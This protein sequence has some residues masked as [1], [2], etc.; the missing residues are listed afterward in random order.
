MV[1]APSLSFRVV[2]CALAAAIVTA[3][4]SDG[5]EP[6]PPGGGTGDA[7]V[8]TSAPGAWSA[9]ASLP[10]AKQELAVVAIGSKVYVLGGL[11]GAG[12]SLAIVHVYDASSDTW[13]IGPPLP[14]PMH[15]VNAAVADGRIY[16]VGA[17]EGAGF[18]ATGDV[19]MLDPSAGAWTP[20][21]PMPAG[22]ERGAAM[23]A[24][25]G[26]VIYVAGGLRSGA[27]ADVSSY[28]TESDE[29]TA[30]PAMDVP[31]DHGAGA[32]VGGIFYAVGGRGAAI[33]AHVP[34]LDAFDPATGQWSPRAPMPTSRAGAAVAVAK[35]R[36]VVIGGEGNANAD[37]GVFAEV[38]SYDPAANA[39]TSLPPMKTPRHGTGAAAINDVVIVPGGGVR[40]ALA[41]TAIVEGLT[42]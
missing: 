13:S 27:V 19:W 28:D 1:H 21:K 34:R 4:G 11:D 17:L 38:E 20:K 9:R 30:R 25:I 12:T 40:Q 8:D 31:R 18:K 32:A 6:S 2:A 3:C 5:D 15:H 29:W 36:I 10:V 42:L 26:K 16:I 23:V 35:G 37:T 22:T 7:A 14:R 39:W 24:A 41:A 33:G